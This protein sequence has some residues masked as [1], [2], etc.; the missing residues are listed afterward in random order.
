VTIATDTYKKPVVE[1]MQAFASLA[2]LPI[3][4]SFKNVLIF[5]A[6]NTV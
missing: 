4:A 6:A 1:L 2:V 3:H 5:A